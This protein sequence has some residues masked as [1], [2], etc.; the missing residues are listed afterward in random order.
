MEQITRFKAID[1]TVFSDREKCLKHEQMCLK[2]DHAMSF[3]LPAEE[4][5]G[6]EFTQ[7][8]K[9]SVIRARNEVVLVL[10]DWL[11]I[12]DDHARA[13]MRAKHN[14][15]IFGRFVDDSGN[16]KAYSAWSRFMSMSP[17]TDREYSQPYYLLQ[18]EK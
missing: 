7:H 8:P 13:A 14:Q 11:G 9:G 1:G 16:K 3:L 6:D 17:V 12:N 2:L 4:L 5:N 18:A 10:A 15:T